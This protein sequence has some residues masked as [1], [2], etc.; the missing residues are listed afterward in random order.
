MTLRWM[1]RMAAIGLGILA[2]QTAAA[3]EPSLTTRKHKVSYAMAV[4]LAKTAQRQG[5]QIDV[6]VFTRGMYDALEEGKLLMTQDEMK[7]VLG[8]VMSEQKRKQERAQARKK[9][10]SVEK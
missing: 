8:G 10:A 4:S 7:Q 2:V 9:A 3:E 6:P 1:R 5:V